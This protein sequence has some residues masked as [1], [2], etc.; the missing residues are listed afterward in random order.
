VERKDGTGPDGG[1][2][3][4]LGSTDVGQQD[5][6]DLLEAERTESGQSDDLV[7]KRLELTKSPQAEWKRSASMTKADCLMDLE[8]W[9]VLDLYKFY[10][11]NKISICRIHTRLK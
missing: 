7:E 6:D 2:I 11:K 5:G 3:E 10:S 8:D 4:I 9:T 1:I